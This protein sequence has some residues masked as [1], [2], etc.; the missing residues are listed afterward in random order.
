MRITHRRGAVRML[1]IGA[2]LAMTLAACSDDEPGTDGTD[3]T[4]A[5]PTPGITDEPCEDAPT[6]TNE[7]CVYLGQITDLTGIFQGA[8][9]Q[10]RAAIEDFWDAVNAEGG[11]NGYD[12]D[13]RTYVED[14]GYDVEA[15]ANAYDTIGGSVFALA[16]SLGTNHTVGILDAM[17]ADN[18][19]AV[20][21]TLWSGWEFEPN[22]LQNGS[23]YCFEAINGVDYAVENF[24]VES[25]MSVHLPGDYGGD[26]AAGTAIAAAGNGIEELEGHE[27]NPNPAELEAAVAQAVQAI[28]TASPDLVVLSLAPDS[29]AGVIGGAVGGGFTGRFMGLVPTDSTPLIAK[30]INTDL[31]PALATSNFVMESLE[32]GAD[33][34][35]HQAALAAAGAH[36]EQPRATNEF[37]TLGFSGQHSMQALLDVV[38][39]GDNPTRAAAVAAIDGL[40]VSYRGMGPDKTYGGDANDTVIRSVTIGELNIER[41]LG[42]ASIEVDYTGPT[43]ADHDFTAPCV[44]VS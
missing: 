18:M 23:N 38:L 22:I 25:V 19:V 8:G 1:A 21:A 34:E 27:F 16:Q 31:Q 35:G 42:L 41:P 30:A 36:E 20:G 37:Y 29:A 11:I 9:T 6:G 39:A 5:G 4:D 13:V 26:G 44:E 10:I 40:T 24:D 43:A 14:T 3:G 17:E 15:H 32:F 7:K 28:L 33:T 2:A 12:I